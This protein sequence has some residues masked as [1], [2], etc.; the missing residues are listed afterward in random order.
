[1]ISYQPE[2][3][4]TP[5]LAKADYQGRSQLKID[6]PV[7][8]FVGRFPKS[9]S[10]QELRAVFATFGSVLECVI[11][12][13]SEKRSKG[14]AFVRFACITD[15][16]TCIEHLNNKHCLDT[17]IGTLQVQFANGEVERLGLKSDQIE[18]PPVK[19]FVGS[20]PKST[21]PDDLQCHF[22]RFGTVVEV[23]ILTDAQGE[24]KGSGFVKMKDRVE[25]QN[26]ITG[27]NDRLF[28]EGST[29]PAEVRL[30]CSKVQKAKISVT[31]PLTTPRPSMKTTPQTQGPPGCNLF[32][33]Q[34]PDTWQD[35]HLV[36]FF[37]SYG[38]V[39]SAQVCRDTRTG[40]SKGY[41]FVSLQSGHKAAEAVERLNGI[42]IEGRRIKV[43]MRR[44]VVD[45]Q[46]P[47]PIKYGLLAGHL[48]MMMTPPTASS[49][50][51]CDYFR[52]MQ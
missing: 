34:I 29:K 31:Q 47:S 24:P 14:C 9:M 36:S 5:Q 21:R 6:V 16:A 10:D 4:L 42:L 12:R 51:A 13:D 48:Q 25:A 15:A 33:V 45:M 7:K 27:L 26:A 2:M 30:A 1:M 39:L 49:S 23:F 43:E 3:L 38:P 17:T 41:G 44:Q 52:R 32:V 22:S 20:L 18:V 35:Q 46:T 19:L 50:A 8:L 40:S 28:L 11:L 37:S